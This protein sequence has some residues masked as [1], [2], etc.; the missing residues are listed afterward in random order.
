ML[1]LENMYHLS[2]LPI[3]HSNEYSLLVAGADDLRGSCAPDSPH[4]L[5]FSIRGNTPPCE[6]YEPETVYGR[7]QQEWEV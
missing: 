2:I 7:K 3:V 6:Q 4:P 5:A 1:V